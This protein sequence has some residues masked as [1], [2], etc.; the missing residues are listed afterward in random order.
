MKT[1][2]ASWI[3]LGCSTQIWSKPPQGTR[4]VAFS[5]VAITKALWV[6]RGQQAAILQH[7]KIQEAYFSRDPEVAIGVICQLGKKHFALLT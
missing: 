1:D 2:A 7:G 5:L 3:A 4:G 6:R